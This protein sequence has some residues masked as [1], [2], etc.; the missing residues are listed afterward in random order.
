VILMLAENVCQG[1]NT[2][3]YLPGAP[4]TNK[5]K[6]YNIDVRE[7]FVASPPLAGVYQPKKGET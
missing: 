4:V 5:K 2:L 7:E 3:A 6:L 1:A